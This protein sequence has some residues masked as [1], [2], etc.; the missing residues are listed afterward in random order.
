[1]RKIIMKLPSSLRTRTTAFSHDILMTVIAWFGAFWVRYNMDVI[2]REDLFSALTMLPVVVIVQGSTFWFTGLYKGVWRFSST[3]DLIRIIKATFIGVA[4]T[5]VAVFLFTRL[6]NIPRSVLLLDGVFLV[7]LLG[8]PR[9]AYRLLRDKAMETGAKQRAIIIGAGRAGEMIVRD[10]LRSAQG[11][12]HPVAFVD[13][14][15]AKKKREI[16]GIP[17]FGPCGNLQDIVDKYNADLIVIALPSATSA[18]I[19]RIV[20]ICEETKTPFRSLPRLQD[21]VT[22]KVGIKELREVTIDDLLGREQVELDWKSI[23]REISGK[24][25][26]VTGG[27]GSIGSEL[28]RQII[29]L[30]PKQLIIFDQSE[31]NLYEIDLELRRDNVAVS[32]VSILGDSKDEIAVN[33]IFDQYRPDIVFHAAAYKHVP[34]LENQVRA[35]VRNNVVG[36]SVVARSEEHTSELQSH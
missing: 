20:G 21:I 1:M 12:Y 14:D 18:E 29:R 36:T 6:E 16:H 35:A 3:P 27:G 25:V 15:P 24:T 30:G 17:V 33:K 34:M 7:L 4:G 8:G 23:G 19:R 11:E 26:L 31:Y 5:T 22:G 32:P 9:F 10:M 2:P 28:C 13:D